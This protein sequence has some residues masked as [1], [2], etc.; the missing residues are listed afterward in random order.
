MSRTKLIHTTVLTRRAG[1]ALLAVGLSTSLAACGKDDAATP[2]ASGSGTPAVSAPATPGASASASAAATPSVKPTVVKDLSA[3]SVTPTTVGK[4]PK[5]TGKWPLAIEKTTVKVL[6]PG[7]GAAVAKGTTV[8]V[9]YQG[10]N[11]RDGKV[12]E[13]SWKNKKPVTFSLK[14]VVPGF[15]KAIEGQKVG[16]RVLVMMTSQDGYADG[17]PSAGIQK[18]DNLVFTIDILGQTEKVAPKAGLP[19]VTDDAKG[20]PSISKPAGKAP[21]KL[22]VQPLTKAPGT[23][24]KI[25]AK[26]MVQVQYRAW[27]WADGKLLQDDY[28]TGPEVGTLSQLIPAWQKGLVGQSAGSRVMI[29]APP[30]DAYGAQG[31]KAQ[32]IPANATIVYVIDVL[33]AQPAQ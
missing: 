6:T 15:T 12:F 28:A 19:T 2:A 31:N 23:A 17:Q 22:T 9:N 21:T 4:E 32:K 16:S 27:N 1:I 13:S 8:S 30:S 29:V 33:A 3:L 7:S 11:A 10:V 26:D 18:G 24:Q 5:V 25:T 20:A 14:S